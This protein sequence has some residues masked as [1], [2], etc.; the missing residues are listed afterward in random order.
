MS[1]VL[2]ALRRHHRRELFWLAVIGALV[3]TQ[4]LIWLRLDKKLF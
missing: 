2:G 3:I 1:A 4:A